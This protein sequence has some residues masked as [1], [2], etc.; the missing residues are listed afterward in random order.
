MKEPPTG[1]PSVTERPEPSLGPCSPSIRDVRSGTPLDSRNRRSLTGLGCLSTLALGERSPNP[2]GNRGSA[3]PGRRRP[4]PPHRG[5]ARP[6]PAPASAAPARRPPAPG[7]PPAAP[8]ARRSGRRCPRYIGMP[9]PGR[10]QPT[11]DH[12]LLEPVQVVGLA[13]DR[14]LGEHLGRLL[15]GGGRDE[16]LR[17]ERRLGDAEQQRLHGRRALALLAACARS[18]ARPAS[19]R[20]ARRPGSRCRR[21]PSPAPCGASGAR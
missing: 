19:C 21:P 2:A 13:P 6:G 5:R 7:A 18:S 4:P 16:R 11:H 9:V 12:V 14:R 20:R 10:D 1:A 15:E 3:Q 17:R 8:R